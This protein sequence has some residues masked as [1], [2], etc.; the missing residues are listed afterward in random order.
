MFYENTNMVT[1]LY[2]AIGTVYVYSWKKIDKNLTHFG[3]AYK[4]KNYIFFL[5]HVVFNLT[6]E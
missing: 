1:V 2:Y 6:I 4:C 3:D 5:L